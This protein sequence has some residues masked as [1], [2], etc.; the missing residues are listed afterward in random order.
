MVKNIIF[1]LIFLLLTS[2][3][4]T[5][6]NGVRHELSQFSRNLD[7]AILT[8]VDRDPTYTDIFLI[9]FCLG[10][11]GNYDHMTIARKRKIRYNLDKIAKEYGYY[12]AIII[13]KKDTV[14]R[15]LIFKELEVQFTKTKKEFDELNNRRRPVF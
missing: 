1:T 14:G 3:A 6:I 7:V 9:Q 10:I 13:D 15:G 5:D 2:C 11:V 12:G 8:L 4:V